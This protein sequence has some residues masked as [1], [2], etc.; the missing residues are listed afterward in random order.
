MA[1]AYA[2]SLIRT[3]RCPAGCLVSS[4][5]LRER[6]ACRYAVGS[7]SADLAISGCASSRAPSWPF[8]PVQPHEELS[9]SARAR[10]PWRLS[11]MPVH[12]VQ[13]VRGPNRPS[14]WTLRFHI[15][16]RPCCRSSFRPAGRY[17]KDFLAVL[18]GE[19]LTPLR[20]DA[21][22]ATPANHTHIQSFGRLLDLPHVSAWGISHGRWGCRTLIP[23]LF[24]RRLRLLEC[25]LIPE[26]RFRGIQLESFSGLS[27]ESWFLRVGI[28]DVSR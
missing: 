16:R 3:D 4:L 17:P 11:S 12:P 24:C 14:P 21:S 18:S 2:R 15:P 7:A 9:R 20:A 13:R 19:T 26:T 25:L 10:L 27:R 6:G 1:R 8:V 22:T 23:Q 5:P 28:S